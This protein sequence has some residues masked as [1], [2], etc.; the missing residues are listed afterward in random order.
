MAGT[1]IFKSAGQSLTGAISKAIIEI[2]DERTTS[3]DV[4]V[5]D[6]KA[7]GASS[8][9]DVGGSKI[10]EAAANIVSASE[11]ITDAVGNLTNQLPVGGSKKKRFEVKFNPSHI[12]FSGV[13]GGKV[14]KTNFMAGGNVDLK[15]QE[16]KPRIQMD[17][18]LIFDDYERTEAFMMEKFSDPMAMIR[19]G[20]GSAINVAKEKTYSVRGQVEGF[21]GALRDDRTRKVTFYWGKLKY[22][23]V[24]I[25][26]NAQYTMFSTDGNPIRAVVNISILN[27]DDS[28]GDA[29]MGQWQE[30][31]DKA[32]GSSDMTNA[33]SVM[34]NVGNLLN[35]KL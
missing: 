24:L 15:Y 11:T 6:V 32:F 8:P 4:E 16:M 14:S 13:G 26:V 28:L 1:D 34:Q 9:L 23:G 2:E 33:G 18:Q 27:T 20:V 7:R 22:T 5:E 12:S 17:L 25:Y 3:K 21:I 31:Y 30:G 35:I 29:Y 19:T 10:A